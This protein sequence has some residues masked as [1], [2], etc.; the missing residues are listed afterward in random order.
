MALAL[1]DGATL[2]SVGDLVLRELGVGV[3]YLAAGLALV[4]GFEW[5]SRRGASL[6]VM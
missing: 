2:G 4:R 5:W 1:A 6:S 3:L